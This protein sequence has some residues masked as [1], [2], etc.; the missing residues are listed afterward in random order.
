MNLFLDTTQDYCHIAIFDNKK[1]IKKI[2]I[3]TN[4]NLTDLVV[5]HIDRLIKLNK[6]NY[7]DLKSIYILIGP[8]SFTGVRVNTLIAKTWATVNNIDVYAIDSL[9]FQL[10]I[11]SGISVLN[12]RGNKR[13]VCIVKAK[14]VILKPK[15]I[16]ENEL[17]KIIL[18]HKNMLVFYDYQDIN[19][20]QN[21]IKHIPN[22]KLIHN[23]KKL[24]P[25]Y[26]KKPIY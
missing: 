8:G 5:E 15:M 14:K 22:F 19:I 11:D 3:K 7:S 4:N 2:S 13:Y 12:A 21:L 1:I 17:K 23:I 6:S 24:T 16:D 9:Y 25:F 10:P 20:F 26:I 18:K